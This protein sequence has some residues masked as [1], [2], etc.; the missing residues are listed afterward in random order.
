MSDIKLYKGLVRYDSDNHKR[1]DSVYSDKFR[2]S[3][4]NG[5]FIFMLIDNLDDTRE[6]VEVYTVYEYNEITREYELKYKE[7]TG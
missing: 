1:N 5:E 2:I 6:W 7:R 4:V 3:T